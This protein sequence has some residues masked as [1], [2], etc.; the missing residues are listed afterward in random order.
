MYQLAYTS[1]SLSKIAEV[2]GK[3]PSVKDNIKKLASNPYEASLK[4]NVP[5]LSDY[6]INSGRYCLLVNIDD[7]S[8]CVE[9]VSVVHRSLLYRI[10]KVA[11]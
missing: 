7:S 1:T 9:I 10:L 6:Y 2:S 4:V 5:G 8:N 11:A 3:H